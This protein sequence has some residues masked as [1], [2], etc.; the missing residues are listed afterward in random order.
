VRNGKNAIVYRASTARKTLHF[1]QRYS[2]VWPTK[3][4][5]GTF[6]FCVNTVSTTGTQS[7]SSCARVTIR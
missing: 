5:H 3:K 6:T 2:M 1:E 4:T 7:P